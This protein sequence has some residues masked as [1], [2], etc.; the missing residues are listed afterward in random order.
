MIIIAAEKI[1]KPIIPM[2]WIPDDVWNANCDSG[3]HVEP[4][5]QDPFD[6]SADHGGQKK[7]A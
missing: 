5:T 4:P 3:V 1:V 2:A 7:G 6:W